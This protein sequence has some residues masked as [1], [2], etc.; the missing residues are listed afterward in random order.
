MLDTAIFVYGSGRSGTTLL[1]KLIDSSPIVLYRHEPDKTLPNTDIPFLPEPED[2]Q[3]YSEEARRYLEELTRE[4]AGVVS[5]KGP[6]FDKSYRNHGSSKIFKL[7]LMVSTMAGKVSLRIQVPDLTNGQR[8]RYLIKSVNSV[9]RVPLFSMAAP[10]MKFVHILRHPVAVAASAR[11]GQQQGKMKGGTFLNSVSKMSNARLL[12]ISPKSLTSASFE[13][14][15]AYS[16]MVQNDKSQREM[17]GK[18]NYLM[19]S[20]EDLC[21]NM[22]E[23][24]ANICDFLDLEFDAQM[25]GFISEMIT[26]HTDTGYFSVIKNPLLSIDKWE[27]S[28]DPAVVDKVV[29]MISHSEVGRFVLD[30][31]SAVTEKLSARTV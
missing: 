27:L 3:N 7:M 13:E 20:Y 25:R 9:S 8:Y 22:S 4:R 16:W 17:Q 30:R 15:F 11:K 5:G 29:A 14:Q 1:A 21:F 6:I 19:V 31:Y 26:S 28:V 12:P 10:G 2:Y 18:L 23:R 24:M